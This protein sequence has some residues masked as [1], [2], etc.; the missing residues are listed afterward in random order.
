MVKLLDRLLLFLFSLAIMFL[1]AIAVLAVFQLIPMRATD[2]FLQDVFDSGFTVSK[3]WVIGAGIV[4][5]LISIRFFYISVRRSRTQ[6][7]SIDQ[8]SEYGDIRISVETVENLSL[9][10]AGRSRGV[11]DLRA[12]VK[13]SEAGLEIGIRTVVDGESSIPELTEEI[14]SAIKN[15]VEEITGIPVS[16][17]SV[18]VANIV[19]NTPTFKSRVE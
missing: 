12:R 8:R 3:A 1:S 9:K 5:F 2:Y 7:P 11:R 14:Q 15:H 19:Q 17:V 16:G 4:I 13:V 6:A 10:A 18:Y